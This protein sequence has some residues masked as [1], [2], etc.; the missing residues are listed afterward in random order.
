M[1][2]YKLKEDEVVLYK[3]NV[4][5]VDEG[6]AQLL[7]TNINVVFIKK[8]QNQENSEI[9]DV[10]TFSVK[11]IKIYK[12]KPQVIAK[13]KNVEIYFLTDEKEIVFTAKGELTKFVNETINLLTDKTTVERNAEKVKN[14]IKIVDDTLGI[15]SVS[16][17]GNAIKDG[18]SGAIGKGLKQL[19]KFLK[20]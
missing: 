19:G 10:E 15:D 20:K 9:V 13:G 8:N 7:L 6:A 3:G 12:E 2:D 11:D 17:A 16:V 14:A 1:K 4:E 18:V 5:I